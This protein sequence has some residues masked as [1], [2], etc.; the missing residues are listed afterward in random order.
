MQASLLLALNLF[1]MLIL[2]PAMMALDVR[3]LFAARFD[4]FCCFGRD[5]SA[6]DA[7]ILHNAN[8]EKV[9]FA[10]SCCFGCDS[11]ATDAAILHNANNEKVSIALSSCFGCDSSATDAAILHNANN[12]KVS[13]AHS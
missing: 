5:S 13:F 4:I 2:F 7:A 10:L 3:R 1:S 12:E 6:T 11:S 8:N 9:S